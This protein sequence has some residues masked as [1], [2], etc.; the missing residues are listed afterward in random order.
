[1]D[2]ASVTKSQENTD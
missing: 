1:M 2:S